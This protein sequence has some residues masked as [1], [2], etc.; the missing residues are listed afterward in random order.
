[1][2]STPRI[3]GRERR[4]VWLW[5]ALIV[6]LTCLPFLVA[7]QVAPT[8]TQYTGLLINH[9]DGESYYAKMQQG[10]RGDWLFHL[11]FTPEP[12]MAPLSL[13]STWVWAS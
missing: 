10:A 4:W 9:Y 8:G 5:S 11:A 1:M 12:M 3:T 13:P 6:G 7:W 2:G